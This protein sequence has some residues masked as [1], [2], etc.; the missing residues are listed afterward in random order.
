MTLLTIQEASEQLRCHPATIRRMIKRG[1]IA[2]VRIGK[3][4]RVDAQAVTP[5]LATPT[6][7][8]V[9]EHSAAYYVQLAQRRP[10]APASR[11][12]LPD[13]PSRSDRT[14]SRR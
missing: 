4:W 3:I 10:S 8:L 1:E 7:A 11:A 2:A 14:G 12:P 13:T 9:E 6:E 5:V